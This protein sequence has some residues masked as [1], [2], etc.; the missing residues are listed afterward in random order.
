MRSPRLLLVLLAISCG[1]SL[2]EESFSDDLATPTRLRLVAAN[3]ST[4]NNQNW[5]AGEGLRI[6]EGLRPDVVMVQEFNYNSNTTQDF[7]SFANAVCGTTCYV[8]RETGSLQIPNGIVSRYPIRS[9]GR[10]VDSAVT[11]RG[12]AWAQID[13]PGPRD[14]W[15][16][17]VH[18]LTNSTARPGE[19]TQL[20]QYIA[21][22]VP[23][24][25]Y[26]AIGGD[27]NTTAR[28]EAVITNLS[29]TVVTTGPFPVDQAGNENTNS[30]R[31]KP[32]DWVLANPALNGL[33]TSAAV[34]AHAYST[35]L[36]VDTRVYSPIS[37]LSPALAGDS[38]AVNMQHMA[39]VRDFMLEAPSDGGVDGGSFDGGWTPDGG[40]F[41]GGSFD[42]GAVDGGWTPDGGSVDGGTTD[43]GGGAGD[44]YEPDDSF[45]SARPIYLGQ[46]QLHDIDPAT[47]ADYVVLKLTA[48]TNVSIET[49]GPL[50]GDT[51][52]RL[53]NSSHSQIAY[54]DDTG[55]GYY[56]LIRRS[57]TAGTYF[58]KATSYVSASVIHGY[59]LR[60][61]TY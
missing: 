24:G 54:D 12:F 52:L 13:I 5:N 28:T 18:L 37:E 30:T 40:S 19:A 4:G 42:G 57:L 22:N 6:L 41:D 33:A 47:D 23:A 56:S 53:Y 49:T 26:V 59:T 10:W 58:I 34:G 50:G 29:N 36:V 35:G 43:G 61:S 46:S 11:N 20:A 32:Y 8:T 55:V 7:Q 16:V 51:Y 21:Q 3:L 48:T 25:D 27:F 9:S 1:G 31:A 38:A 39:V 2:G 17:S 44:I 15:V 45:A 14:L 60:V